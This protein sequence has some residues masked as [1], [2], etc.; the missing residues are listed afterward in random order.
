MRH[1]PRAAILMA[2]LASFTTYLIPLFHLEAGWLPLGTTLSGIRNVGAASLAWILGTLLLQVGAFCLVLWLLGRINWSRI[3]VFFAAVPVFMLAANLILLWWIPLYML[4]ERDTAAEIGS[5]EKVCTIPGATVAQVRSGSDLSLVRAGEAWLDT[6]GGRSRS[7]LTMPG[8]RLI[9]L[10]GRFDGTTI[11]A[12]APGGLVLHRQM[13][14]EIGYLDPAARR[15]A[16]LSQPHGVAYWKPIL[17]DDGQALVWLDRLSSGDDLGTP[18][19]HLR[20]LVTGNE[21]KVPIRL[22]GPDQIELLGASSHNGPFTLARFRNAIFQIDPNGDIVRGPVSPDGVYD[23][24]WGFA[25]LD[26]GWVAWDGYREDGRSRI[27]WDIPNGSGERSIPLGQR[28]DS[29]AV[30]ADGDLIAV[31]VSSNLRIGN[32]QSSVFVFRT[33]NGEEVYRRRHPVQVR[34]AVAFLGDVY[35]AV[36]EI[37]ANQGS[38]GVYRVDAV[39]RGPG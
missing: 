17:S 23:A 35:L 14:G 4:V 2:F 10:D 29:L 13:S 34:S 1:R 39:A 38:V 3:L 27:V 22:P 25:W 20:D 16:A 19:L 24:R 32:V 28:I 30:A 37:E 31:A 26:G 11:D 21:R 9:A 33:D 36:T 18:H 7:I 15:F 6:D 8:C 5:P 12:V